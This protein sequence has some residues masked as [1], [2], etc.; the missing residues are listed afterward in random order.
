MSSIGLDISGG[1]SAWKAE[2]MRVSP[3]DGV[4]LHYGKVEDGKIEYVK[5]HDYEVAS[6]LGDVEMT[7][8]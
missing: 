4:V 8:K 6:F 3:A 1:K 7:Q 5:G 2:I